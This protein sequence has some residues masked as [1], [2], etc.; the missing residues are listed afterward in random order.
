MLQRHVIPYVAPKWYEL[1][2][3]L[4]DEKEEYMLNTIDTDHKKDVNKCCHEMFRKWL[5][6]HTNATWY[7][8]LEALKSPGVQ[9]G[10][11]AAEL[12]ENLIGKNSC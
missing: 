8:I 6:T 7:L 4:F 11:V 5:M 9:L 2:A 10:P 1:G 3:E 12:E